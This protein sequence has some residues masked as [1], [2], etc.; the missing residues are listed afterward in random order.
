M[1]SR[2]KRERLELSFFINP[3]TGKVQYNRQ[4]RRCVNDC[5]QSYRTVIIACKNYERKKEGEV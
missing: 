3:V 2:S 4:C 5:R 1:N